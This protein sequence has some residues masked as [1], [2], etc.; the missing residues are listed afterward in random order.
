M[1]Y[2]GKRYLFQFLKNYGYEVPKMKE[3]I[4]EKYRGNEW[5]K[6]AFEE[7]R[8]YSPQRGVIYVTINEIDDETGK[9][10]ELEY[11]KYVYGVLDYQT[12]RGKIRYRDGKRVYTA[13]DYMR[14]AEL[15]A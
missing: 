10:T 2:Y 12:R 9:K 15:K 7:I 8:L 14:I 4:Y 5:L 11:S 1:K 13:A 6:T 3:M